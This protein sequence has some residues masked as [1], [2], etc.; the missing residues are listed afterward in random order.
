ME[1]SLIKTV[2]ICA[3]KHLKNEKFNLQNTP[4]VGERKRELDSLG[5]FFPTES[6]IDKPRRLFH[7][8]RNCL[9]YIF[10]AGGVCYDIHSTRLKGFSALCH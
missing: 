1:R 8:R 10:A 2:I 3:P 5:T 9:R 7:M 6:G 4:G